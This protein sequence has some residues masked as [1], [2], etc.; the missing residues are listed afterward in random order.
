MARSLAC[1]PSTSAVVPSF[2]SVGID[3]QIA[4]DLSTRVAGEISVEVSDVIVEIDMPGLM[5]GMG[6]FFEEQLPL[7]LEPALRQS[8]SDRA[9]TACQ[10]L[11]TGR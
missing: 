9:V 1:E 10:Q 7:L 3:A 8:L 6:E 11:K 4:I 5:S 2:V